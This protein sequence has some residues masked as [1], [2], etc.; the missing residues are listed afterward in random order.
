MLDVDPNNTQRS[1]Y[2]VNTVTPSIKFLYEYKPS[3]NSEWSFTS[4]ITIQDGMNKERLHYTKPAGDFDKTVSRFTHNWKP[5]V[6]LETTRETKTQTN[7]TTLSYSYSNAHPD[8][9]NLLNL[10][11]DSNPYNIYESN[12]NLKPSQHHSV[13]LSHTRYKKET[14]R[15][16]VMKAGYSRTDN[17][18]AQAVHYNRNTG[19]TTRRAENINGN[20][21]ASAS[22]S[23][24]LSF[25]Q[26]QQFDLS[27]STS[28]DFVHSVDYTPE[29][30]DV[31]RSEVN[32]FS[33]GHRVSLGCKLGKQH[34]NV[35]G[36]ASWYHARSE[37]ENFEN[38]DAFN[39]SL[40]LS[41]TFNLP[42]S[43]QITTN[44]SLANRC[45]YS[46]ATLNETNWVWNAGISKTLLKGK[47]TMRLD[48][49]DILSQQS[50]V[51]RVINAQGNTETWVNSQP[52]YFLFSAI[53][54]FTK[55][56]K[57]KK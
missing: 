21:S 47:L 3:D 22:V 34:I 18:I 31:V 10:T 29:T 36:S 57:K 4:N 15:N 56:P 6:S 55:I 14:H 50:A 27:N 39:F 20:W 52:R 48:G 45:G 30:E 54:R 12:D 28:A 35:S 11:N 41:G 26:S 51:S 19:V 8:I 16:L 9:N 33:L 24:T 32:N 1:R 49:Y 40:G 7:V 38:I 42:K 2:Y 13:S 17:S 23:Y 53:Y 5:S 46:D 44:F 43:W 37:R 25:G